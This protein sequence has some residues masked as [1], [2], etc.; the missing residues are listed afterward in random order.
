MH[1]KYIF[2]GNKLIKLLTYYG[3]SDSWS[4]AIKN[5]IAV[6]FSFLAAYIVYLVIKNIL[7]EI[8]KHFTLKTATIWDDIF[9]EQ[10][11]FH[12]C[13]QLF[14]ILLLYF[15]LEFVLADDAQSILPVV[16]IIMQIVLLITVLQIMLAFTNSMHEI[17]KTLPYSKNRPITGYVQVV[18]IFIWAVIVIFILSVILHKSPIFFLSGLGA[19]AAVL[20]LIFKDTILG[21]VASI[22]L[23]ANKMLKPGDWISMPKY[24]AE[25]PV[26]EISI[27]TVKI[28]NTDKTISL[29]PTYTLVS[30]SFKNW[31]NLEEIQ[32]RRIKRSIVIDVNTIKFC[33]ND[34][35]KKFETFESLKSYIETNKSKSNFLTGSN[36]TNIGLFRAYIEGYVRTNSEV[37]QDL[38]IMVRYLQQTETG[39]PIEL[40]CFAKYTDLTNYEKV[41]SDIFEHIFAVVSWFELKIFQIPTG[42]D[43][44]NL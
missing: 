39:L 25:G 14:P 3:L 27:N 42:L 34:M 33:S 10:K 23:S 2:F 40:I 8:I 4:I 20:L 31:S 38:Q 28:Q 16:L 19:V 12:R 18:K 37:N 24:N 30:D 13:A 11:F 41:Q 43:V 15:L 17:Y 1:Q 22:Q 21:F 35:L 9:V 7:I 5:M 44:K 26:L 29:I 6:L 32:G 36:I